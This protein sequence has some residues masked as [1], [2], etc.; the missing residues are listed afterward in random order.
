MLDPTVTLPKLKAPGVTL[1]V[2][3][4]PVVPE[5]GIDRLGTLDATEMLPV[6]VLAPVGVKVTL[7]VMLCPAAN[8][9]GSPGAVKVN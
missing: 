6:A 8:V 1:R 4:A 2:P 5:S 3:V 7:S 9:S